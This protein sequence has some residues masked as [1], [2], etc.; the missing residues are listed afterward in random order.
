MSILSP[1]EGEGDGDTISFPYWNLPHNPPFLNF[2][3][4]TVNIRSHDSIIFSY[5]SSVHLLYTI[6]HYE[7]LFFIVK[8]L[9]LENW[10]RADCNFFEFH[11]TVYNILLILHHRYSEKDKTLAF[12]KQ[13]FQ[14]LFNCARLRFIIIIFV[15]PHS[16]DS[17]KNNLYLMERD[18]EPESTID[19]KWYT[20]QC[21]F[22][23]LLHTRGNIFCL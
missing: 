14:M 20:I 16:C 23:I 18:K 19:H 4:I 22:E 5:H 11:S 10:G 3:I 2:N 15:Y 1:E 21:H 17:V 6:V 7:S 8:N 13:F 12:L 9:E